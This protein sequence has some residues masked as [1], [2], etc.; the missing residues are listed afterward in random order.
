M[1]WRVRHESRPTAYRLGEQRVG[2]EQQ[3]ADRGR[4]R[5]AATAEVAA[6]VQV[7][8]SPDPSTGIAPRL[9]SLGGRRR[10]YFPSVGS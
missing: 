2:S 7:G 9:F 5:I 1:V 4:P 10:R 3:S 6:A 8:P